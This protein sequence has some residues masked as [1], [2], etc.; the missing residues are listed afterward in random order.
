MAFKTPRLTHE[1]MV[2][3]LTPSACATCLIF[4]NFVF[5]SIAFSVSYWRPILKEKRV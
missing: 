4:T 5:L 3:S 2:S 1:R